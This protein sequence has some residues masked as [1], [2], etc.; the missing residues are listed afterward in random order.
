MKPL[1]KQ[2]TAIFNKLIEGL[3]KLGD[4]R[5]WDNAQGCF[6][7][8]CIEIIDETKA[9]KIVSVAHYYEQNSDLM[10]DPDV[11][12][13]ISNGTFTS[14][15]VGVFPL[16]FRQDNLGI[17]RQTAAVRED[18]HIVCYPKQQRDLTRFCDQWMTNI[19]D[20]QFINEDNNDRTS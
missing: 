1:S 2:A 16:S 6:M 3:T 5:K 15:E 12:F 7:A 8:A 18:G 19:A 14:E 9:G 17:D 10:R 20:Q 13:L 4:H 11:C